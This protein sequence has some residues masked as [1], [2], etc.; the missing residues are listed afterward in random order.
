M[1]TPIM[2]KWQ[3]R[4]TR[5]RC[6][7]PAQDLFFRMH[8]PTQKNR[9]GPDFGTQYRSVIF[10]HSPEQAHIA[11]EEK[12]KVEASGKWKQPVVTQIEPAPTFWKAEESHQRY[13]QKHGGSCHG[14]QSCRRSEERS[15]QRNGQWT[16]SRRPLREPRTAGREKRAAVWN[17]TRGNWP[18][19][20]FWAWRWVYACGGW[21]RRGLVGIRCWANCWCCLC[22]GI[23]LSPWC[24]SG[25][26]CAGQPR[27]TCAATHRPLRIHLPFAGSKSSTTTALPSTGSAAPP[28]WLIF[29]LGWSYIR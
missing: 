8:N 2:P 11:A 14:L 16:I 23:F 7:T 13:F 28:P 19:R 26:K 18:V 6:P 29:I 5:Q 20:V 21:R 3:R 27:K 22:A 1:T 15:Q 17:T 24:P 4:S 9:Q 25:T 12:A 10:T